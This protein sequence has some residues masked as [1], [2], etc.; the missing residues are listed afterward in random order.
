MSELNFIS[1]EKK[2]TVATY[3]SELSKISKNIDALSI[4]KLY[5]TVDSETP[6]E[7]EMFAWYVDISL[8]WDGTVEIEKILEIIDAIYWEDFIWDRLYYRIESFEGSNICSDWYY[9]NSEE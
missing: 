3:L 2:N 6:S 1:E 5:I 7:D 4:W 8:L 9:I